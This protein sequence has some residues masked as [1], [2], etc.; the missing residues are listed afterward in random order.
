MIALDRFG[1]TGYL[2]D[3]DWR[4]S[5]TADPDMC[6]VLGQ[7]QAAWCAEE[8]SQRGGIPCG[9]GKA[10]LGHMDPDEET[11][12]WGGLGLG[13]LRKKLKTTA[14]GI[15]RFSCLGRALLYIPDALT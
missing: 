14:F 6:Q 12:A 13:H 11:K 5:Q 10:Q 7:G 9:G 2:T 8:D 3:S 15:Q 1:V 4:S